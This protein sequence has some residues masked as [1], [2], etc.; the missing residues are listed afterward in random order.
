MRHSSLV[1]LAFVSAVVALP[2]PQD[3]S[4]GEDCSLTGTCNGGGAASTSTAEGTGVIPTGIDNTTNSTGPESGTASGAIP[5]GLLACGEAFY[6]PLGYTCYNTFLCPIIDGTPTLQCGEAC[7]LPALYSCADNTLQTL[8]N[9]TGSSSSNGTTDA[10]GTTDPATSATPTPSESTGVTTMGATTTSDA[11]STA[12]ATPITEDPITAGDPNTAGNPNTAGDPTTAGN[13]NTAGDPNANSTNTF[14]NTPPEGTDP[15]APIVQPPA[16]NG[17][18][19]TTDPSS[20]GTEPIPTTPD[21]SGQSGQGNRKRHG[22][23]DGKR[24][25]KGGKKMMRR[26][27]DSNC[28]S[29]NCVDGLGSS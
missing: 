17:T 25:G 15:N 3:G 13:P 21:E 10:S 14:F 4:T 12:T 1:T 16:T 19:I 9:G 23:G 7:Y 6:D 8:N 5:T 28:L 20:G 26:E 22:K 27:A 18:Q 11:T 24:H 29:G 2:R